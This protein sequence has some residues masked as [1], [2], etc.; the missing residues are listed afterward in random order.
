MKAAVPVKSVVL[1]NSRSNE[2]VRGWLV[3]EEQIDD[4]KYW[5]VMQDKRPGARLRFAKDAWSIQKG[6]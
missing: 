6:K 4:K 1:K 3:D 2:T 5:V